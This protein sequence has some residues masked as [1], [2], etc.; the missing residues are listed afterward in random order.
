[1]NSNR[2][3]TLIEAL[4]SIALI[5]LAVTLIFGMFPQTRLAM[6]LSEN[7]SSAAFFGRSLINNLAVSGFDNM[8]NAS[9]TYTF[10]GTDNGRPFTFPVNYTI[11][12]QLID[13]DKK[14]VWVTITWK[15]KSGSKQVIVETLFTKTS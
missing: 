11:T 14:L 8:Q 12:V 5:V 1:M 13:T 9:G 6:Q 2:G 10:S 3:F 4:V 7:R 15:E